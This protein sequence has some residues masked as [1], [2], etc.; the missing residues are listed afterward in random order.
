MNLETLI[1]LSTKEPL[2]S[3]A[4]QRVCVQERMPVERVLDAFATKVAEGYCAGRY[5]WQFGDVAMNALYTYAYVLSDTCLSDHAMGMY[6][7]F[8]EGEY[9]HPGD[10]KDF[11]GELRTHELLHGLGF[12]AYRS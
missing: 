10:P 5:S 8:D 7:A 3:A 9:R 12:D 11:D 1:E 6:E 4:I 2:D